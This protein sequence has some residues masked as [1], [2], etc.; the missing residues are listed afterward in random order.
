MVSIKLYFQR[1]IDYWVT[2]WQLLNG[3]RTKAESS[4][5]NERL[6]DLIPYLLNFEKMRVLDLAN[7]RLRPQFYLL[8]NEEFQA[9]G[10]DLVNGSQPFIKDIINN[11]ARW[12]YTR[13]EGLQGYFGKNTNLVCGDVANLP[14]SDKSFN[15]VT[16]I[17]AFE[18][19]LDVPAVISEIHRVLSPGGVA[20]IRIHLFTCPSGAHNLS[21]TEI[22]LIKIPKGV[23]P[24][25]HLRE[26]K[27]PITVPLNEWRLHQYID[28]FSS[29][30]TILNN[31]TVL[32]EGEHLL[33]P[34]IENE[35]IDYTRDELTS[36][37][38]MIIAQKVS[39]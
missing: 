15:M 24:W 37:S 1:L 26:R 13:H 31:Y 5:A 2:L 28:A 12:L 17:A 6:Q 9:F 22:P 14:Y 30:F 7:G 11:F 35:L 27:L 20:W 21:L 4:V 18:H 34:E 3:S 38:F 39:V 33:N 19:F 32:R 10:I 16:S 29:K 36:G 8:N 23:D 25:D